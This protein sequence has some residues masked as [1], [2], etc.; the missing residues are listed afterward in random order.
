MMHVTLRQLLSVGPF[1]GQIASS[2]KKLAFSGTTL[3]K[4]IPF[5]KM[6]GVREN[7]L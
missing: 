2:I 4:K 5:F 6:I 7:I 3:E 1:K